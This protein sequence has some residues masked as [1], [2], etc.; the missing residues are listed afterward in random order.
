MLKKKNPFLCYS[1]ARVQTGRDDQEGLRKD[2]GSPN[3][4]EAC[5]LA[6]ARS[7]IRFYF[8]T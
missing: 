6:Q 1:P 8:L 2:P 5:A 7:L 4:Q 3:C